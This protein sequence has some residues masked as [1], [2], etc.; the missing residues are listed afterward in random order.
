MKFNDKKFVENTK[1]QAEAHIKALAEGKNVRD[2][3][4]DIYMTLEG[5]TED[6]SYIMADRVIESVEKYHKDFE[7]CYENEDDYIKQ[8]LAEAT[9]NTKSAKERCEAYHRMLVAIAAH[10]IITDGGENAEDRANAYIEENKEFNCTAEEAEAKEK[11]LYELTV[12]SIKNTDLI[13]P[14]LASILENI[15]SEELKNTAGSYAF[16][17][18]S[19]DIKAILAMQ[20]Y[21]NIQNGTVTDLSPDMTLEQIS[22]NVCGAVDTCAVAAQ[23]EA[24]ELPKEIA[25]KILKVI[26]QI[27]GIGF[28][29]FG[30]ISLVG[31]S[32]IILYIISPFSFF[33][34]LVLATLIT[35]IVV[36][37]LDLVQGFKDLGGSIFEGVGFVFG[38]IVGSVIK[39][40]EKLVEWVSPYVKKAYN[41]VKEKV[42]SFISYLRTGKAP[43]KE[44]KEVKTEV[45]EEVSATVVVAEEE[46][47]E[48]EFNGGDLALA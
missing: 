34:S 2:I 44:D 14:Q 10:S 29:A 39:G 28:L 9:K 15:S 5:K 19:K 42:C 17:R 30:V 26:G 20:T 38:Y 33:V 18:K 27:L 23:A 45:S 46:I 24:G 31:I 12:E 13:T 48:K 43:V 21:V 47:K 7:N 3:L 41:W 36:R 25:M 22:Y 1:A 37:S 32:S 16:G 35:A 8:S 40:I 11:E 6:I 4:K